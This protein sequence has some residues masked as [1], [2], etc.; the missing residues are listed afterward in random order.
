MN[1]LSRHRLVLGAALCAIAAM[2]FA[3]FGGPDWV[4]FNHSASIPAGLY[5]RT[6]DGVH[7]GSVVTVRARDV[8]PVEAH[9]RQFE[10]VTD[11]FIKRVAASA[12]ATVC[13]ENG[14]LFV[15]G[16][17]RA[18]VLEGAS[19]TLGWSGCRILAESE[20][21]LLG[22][23]ADSFDGRYWGPT[24]IDLIEGVWRRL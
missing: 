7:V 5:L 15:D 24:S 10:D 1:R 17:M 9:Q 2:G 13:G 22:D 18:E 14:R 8:A 23:S 3:I 12:G 16:V 20:V 19:V 6:G 21:L 11:R 4:V